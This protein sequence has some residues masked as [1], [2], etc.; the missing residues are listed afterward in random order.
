M[1]QIADVLGSCDRLRFL[2]PT[3]HR[4]LMS[5]LRFSLREARETRT[6]IDLPSLELTRADEAAMRVLSRWQA[7]E[8]VMAFG[9]G[10]ALERPA[11]KAIVASAAIG[12]LSKASLE[13]GVYFDGGRGVQRVWLEATARGLAFQP[14]SAL[15]YL[16][17]R[18]E[19][20][21]G[22]G[23]NDL[24]RASLRGLRQRLD[25]A[26]PKPDGHTEL[27]LFR[28]AYADAPT[29]RALRLSVDE[30]CSFVS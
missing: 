13:R 12:L 20:G 14:Y 28:L 26:L 7:M 1:R 24:E 4:D 22:A 15:L 27:L 21:L 3:M 11:Q 9:G 6:G 5:E 2:S 8:R 19:R 29:S 10:K 30:I 23:L 25:A 16:L 18:L 17:A